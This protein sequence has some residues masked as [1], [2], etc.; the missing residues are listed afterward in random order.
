MKDSEAIIKH[1]V[2]QFGTVPLSLL[3]LKLTEEI[4]EVAADV[5]RYDTT[6]DEHHMNNAL[7]EIGDVLVVLS[8]LAAYLGGDLEDIYEK[9]TNR[10]CSR[11]FQPIKTQRK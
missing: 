11:I 8:V 2:N 10:F 3:M 1:H 5:Y 7:V 9:S 4:G 6:F